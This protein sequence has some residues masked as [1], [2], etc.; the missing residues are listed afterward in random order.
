MKPVLR[1]ATPEDIDAA[2]DA[3]DKAHEP[4]SPAKEKAAEQGLDMTHRQRRVRPRRRP[5]H[6]L[7][8]GP[9]ARRLSQPRAGPLARPRRPR[10]AAAGRRPRPRQARRRLRHLR[11]APLLLV[12]DDQLP[13]RQHPHGEG[14]RPAAQPSEDL[15]RLRPPLLLPDLRIRRLQGA[16]RQAAQGRLHASRRPP[17]KPKSWASTS[18]ARSSSCGSRSTYVLSKSPPSTSSCRTA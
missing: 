12:L 6:G 17:A 5:V 18:T 4:C 8:L 16:A 3:Q 11:R 7:L 10:P 1:I 9:G 15:R 14:A 2:R 13:Q